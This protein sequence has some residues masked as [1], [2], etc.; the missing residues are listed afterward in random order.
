MSFPSYS[1][2]CAQPGG[3]DAECLAADLVY[4]SALHLPGEFLPQ[5]GQSVPTLT[6][7]RGLQQFIR[8]AIPPPP[9]RHGSRPTQ[10]P[11][12]LSSKGWVYVQKD[13]YRRPLTR[14]YSGPFHIVEVHDKYFILDVN[15]LND[16][17][18]IE[19]LKIAHGQ[20]L[21]PP[22]PSRAIPEA[23]QT[24]ASLGRTL[25]APT[26]RPLP[27]LGAT[28]WHRNG[29]TTTDGKADPFL[30]RPS[31]LLPPGRLDT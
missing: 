16:P 20:A 5:T 8:N 15:G 4:R 13:G 23:P 3:E 27:T 21:Q 7:L 18:S 1:S 29:Q 2:G 10:V 28:S 22:A 9:V 6:F 30:I 25:P 11:S 12:D 24:P 31:H 14:P 17:V 19:R 26:A